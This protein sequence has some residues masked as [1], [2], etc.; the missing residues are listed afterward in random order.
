MRSPPG[1]KA[2]W[3]IAV[4]DEGGFSCE[5]CKTNYTRIRI[6]GGQGRCLP[7]APLP[8]CGSLNRSNCKAEARCQWISPNRGGPLAGSCA[9][10]CGDYNVT[11]PIGCKSAWCVVD[12]AN[13][14]KVLCEKCKSGFRLNRFDNY[15]KCQKEFR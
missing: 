5:K 7:N 12:V 2:A 6:D 14:D 10:K 11:T 3:C 4:D 13:G 15:G 1:C 9:P 8:D